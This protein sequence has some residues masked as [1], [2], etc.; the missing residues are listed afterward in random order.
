[1][2]L[3][4]CLLQMVTSHPGTTPGSA[5]LCTVTRRSV[6]LWWPPQRIIIAGATAGAVMAIHGGAE[7]LKKPREID[8]LTEENHRLKPRLRDQERH[9]T[10]GFFGAATPSAK[11]PVKAHTPPSQEPKRKGARPGHPGAGRQA[12]E[13]SQAERVVDVEAAL[14]DR[15]PDG[16]SPLADKGSASR[17]VL[18]SRPVKAERVLY[19]LPKRSGPRCRRTFQPPAPAVLPKSLSGH[20]L[21]ATAA[22]MH[23]L[24]GI[25][26]GKVGDQ[27]GLGPGS[28]VEIFHRLARRLAGIP[29]R[30]VEEYRQAPGKHADETGW[31]THGNKGSTW[32]FATPRLSLFLFRRTRAASVPPHVFGK[33]QLPGGLVVDRDGGYNKLP[34]AIQYGYSHLRREV[35]TLEK[36]FPD[37]AEVTAFVSTVAPQ[38]ALAMGRRAQP[39]SA[40]EFCRQAGALKVQSCATMEA[41][42]QHLGIRR[43]QAIFRANADRLSHGADDRHVPA[44]NHLAERDL[45]PTV[46]ARKVSFGSPSDAG[47]HTRGILMSVW[48][49]LKKQQVDVVAHLKG[50]L[51]QLAMDFCQDPF[52]LL[53]PNG[54]T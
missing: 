47:A 14:G 30:L 16:D 9:A 3:G 10:A 25:P 6:I 36:E 45:R 23:D 19:R 8:R 41:P 34:C 2:T 48:H 13:V 32:L 17:A 12:F 7:C 39:S 28:L 18:E 1:M 22:T 46:M 49:T 52:P 21:V 29:D 40:P 38:L 44:D 42:S 33:T 35:Q 26:L 54:P 11:R 24:H 53:F 15:G 37:A 5:S 50:V 4:P 31:R 51:D 43:I 20:Q 27:T